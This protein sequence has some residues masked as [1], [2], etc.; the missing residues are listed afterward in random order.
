MHKLKMIKQ[1]GY[2]RECINKVYGVKFSRSDVAVRF[3][4]EQC[5]RCGEVKNIVYSVKV[6]SLWKLLFLKNVKK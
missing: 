2:C 1:A 4:P 3:Y 5:S 6:H